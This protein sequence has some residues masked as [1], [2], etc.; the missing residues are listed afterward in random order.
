MYG[1]LPEH[2]GTKALL[3]LL[4][5]GFGGHGK[6]GGC[7]HEYVRDLDPLLVFKY[8]LPTGEMLWPS[9]KKI[10]QEIMLANYQDIRILIVR[11]YWC[12]YNSHCQNPA[13]LAEGHEQRQRKNFDMIIAQGYLDILNE[14][15]QTPVPFYFVSYEAMV[16]NPERFFMD[17][18]TC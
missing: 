15:Q 6:R 4:I 12:L 3:N 1:I 17:Y 13:H 11:D 8:S 18:L 14:L 16:T 9:P 2:T 10:I 5:D 7:G